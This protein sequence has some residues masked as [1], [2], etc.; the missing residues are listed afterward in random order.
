MDSLA[1]VALH[2]WWHHL[3]ATHYHTPNLAKA[4]CGEALYLDVFDALLHESSGPTSWILV[5]ILPYS[6]LKSTSTSQVC[7]RDSIYIFVHVVNDEPE[8][9][10]LKLYALEYFAFGIAELI[11][12]TIGWGLNW[13]PLCYM[14][15][16]SR[17]CFTASTG[18]LPWYNGLGP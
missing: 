6:S 9:F 1:V 4:S 5:I 13:L 8:G 18:W 14:G 10:W 11:M 12:V 2:F 16:R 7:C 17:G 3:I 15:N